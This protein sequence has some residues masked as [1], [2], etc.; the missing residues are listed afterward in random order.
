MPVNWI[1]QGRVLTG[2]LAGEIDHHAAK[3]IMAQLAQQ[4]DAALPEQLVL[5]LKEV[6]FM[7]SS[8][9]AVVLNAWRRMGQLEGTLV[10]R[11]VPP[12]AGKVLRAAGLDKL[13]TIEE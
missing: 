8:G 7:D 5:E 9:I 11:Q 2:R 1:E 6:T 3:E 10:V 4:I 13:L 12:Q